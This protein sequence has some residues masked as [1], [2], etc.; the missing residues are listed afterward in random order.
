MFWG[1]SFINGSLKRIV[2]NL[3]DV[4]RSGR[5]QGELFEGIMNYLSKKQDLFENGVGEI[6]RACEIA[7]SFNHRIELHDRHLKLLIDLGQKGIVMIERHHEDYMKWKRLNTLL[8]S[9]GHFKFSLGKVE[10]DPALIEEAFYEFRN[11]N[12]ARTILK[13]YNDSTHPPIDLERSSDV[14]VHLA[15][16]NT[17]SRVKK[18]QWYHR[19]VAARRG[20][21]GV[22]LKL[23]DD[24]AIAGIGRRCRYW[25]DEAEDNVLA[26]R[27]G[28]QSFI[29]WEREGFEILFQSFGAGMRLNQI[30]ETESMVDGMLGIAPTLEDIFK[31]GHY[32]QRASI[33]ADVWEEKYC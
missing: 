18:D 10:Y 24:K 28:F 23:G 31:R 11:A 4:L 29:G 15:R 6:A 14:A 3:L 17:T 25:I 20:V 33:C 12:E 2:M 27:L 7:R 16:M 19:A 8:S 5:T 26:C 22:Y 30:D 1:E 9:L 13:S 32:V 21:L